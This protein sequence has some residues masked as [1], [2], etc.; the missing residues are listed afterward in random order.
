MIYISLKGGLGNILFQIA[1]AKSLSV[2]NNVEFSVTN[3]DEQIKLLNNDNHYNPLLTHAEEYRLI[4][5]NIL[6]KKPDKNILMISYP[7]EYHNIQ[8]PKQDVLI[9]GFFQSEKYFLHNRK[10]IIEFLSPPDFIKETIKTK[11]SF[12]NDTR[13]SSI[14][15]RRGDYLRHVEYHP[16]Q[17]LEYYKKSIEILK[18]KTDLFVVFSD[19]I[20]WCKES[21]KLDNIIYIENEKDYIELYLMSMC[22]NNVIANSSFSWWGAWLNQN[23]NKIVISPTKWFG[24]KITSSSKDII[25][26]SWVKI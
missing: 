3:L 9:D 2:D 4:L 25:P 5:P 24:P 17:T 19:D 16:T 21:L 7:F 8:L 13:T 23:E 6:N 12:I 11:Y 14:H 22:N 1:A 15:V 20:D 18:D 10:E 26:D